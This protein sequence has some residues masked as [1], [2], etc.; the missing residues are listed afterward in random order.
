MT[1]HKSDIEFVN[2]NEISE[3][4]KFKF[5]KIDGIYDCSKIQRQCELDSIKIT[6]IDF[7]IK[8]KTTYFDYEYVLNTIDYQLQR[9]KL[10][11]MNIDFTKHLYINQKM[12]TILL[13][14]LYQVHIKFKMSPETLY[15]TH[16]VISRY[17]TTEHDIK[18]QKLQLV[19]IASFYMCSKYEDVTPPDIKNMVYICDNACNKQEIIDMEWKIMS[20]F[21][22]NLLLIPN[23]YTFVSLFNFFGQFDKQCVTCIMYLCNTS[24]LHTSF[25]QYKLSE[26]VASTIA[27]SRIYINCDDNDIFPNEFVFCSCYILDDLKKCI[28]TFYDF[29]SDTKNLN[30]NINQVYIKYSNIKFDQ[31]AV[32]FEKCD[33]KRL[34]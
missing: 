11:D 23:I 33:W 32:K 15:L 18:R 5:Q 13:N 26:I 16:Q 8:K 22:F 27:I 21:N 30:S 17:L 19:G 2:I 28:K 29:F 3:T 1:K 9:E 7:S 25:L 10:I 14:W 4:I 20:K 6:Q 24:V 12:Y 31:I 34:I